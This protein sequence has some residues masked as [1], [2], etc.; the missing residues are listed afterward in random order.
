MEHSIEVQLPFLQYLYGEAIEVLAISMGDQGIEMNLSLGAALAQVLQGHECALLASTDFSHYLPH[1]TTRDQDSYAVEAIQRLDPRRLNKE[2][3]ERDIGMCGM[4]P[5]TA[6]MECMRLM[7]AEE[8]RLLG[9]G[10]LA[11]ISVDYCR[12]VGYGAFEVTVG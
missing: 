10:T 2:V 8:A 4:G 6:V 11:D 5:V 7:G 12:V 1:R 3:M 9:Y